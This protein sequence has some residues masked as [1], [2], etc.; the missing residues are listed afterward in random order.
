MTTLYIS[1]F[2]LFYTLTIQ[3]ALA[4]DNLDHATIINIQHHPMGAS[5]LQAS[6]EN[7]AAKFQATFH[8]R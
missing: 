2:H 7:V 8:T 6:E 1:V 5:V 4:F 3:T